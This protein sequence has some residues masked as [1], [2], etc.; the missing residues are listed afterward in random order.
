MVTYTDPTAGDDAVAIK[1]A[2]GNETATFTTG[3]NSV[4][5]VVNNSTA[6]AGDTTAPTLTSAAG[7]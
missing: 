7:E 5:D 2:A 3:V 1:D 6:V 4:P